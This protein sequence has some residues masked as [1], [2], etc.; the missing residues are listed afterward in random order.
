MANGEQG[1]YSGVAVSKFQ[2]A[3]VPDRKNNLW[4]SIPP[5][6]MSAD[7]GDEEGKATGKHQLR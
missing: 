7:S 6:D 3:L 2:R 1:L 5:L 4:Y